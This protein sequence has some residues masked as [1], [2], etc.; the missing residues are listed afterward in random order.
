MESIFK[1]KE[2]FWL[3]GS[4]IKGPVLTVTSPDT[5]GKESVF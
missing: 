1:G 4:L 3:S 5:R 2:I